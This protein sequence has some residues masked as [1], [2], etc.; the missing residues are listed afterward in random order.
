[1]RFW[2]QHIG[3][4]LIT[5]ICKR[6]EKKVLSWRKTYHFPTFSIH[7]FGRKLLSRLFLLAFFSV[8]LHFYKLYCNK[9]TQNANTKYK[10]SNTAFCQFQGSS[11]YWNIKRFS[12]RKYAQEVN[13]L[14]L[15]A[16]KFHIHRIVQNCENCPNFEN[17][18]F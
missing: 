7:S 4:C 10:V 16:F 12:F 8:T 9:K 11:W 6:Y 2:T 15:N 14:Y 1:M 18:I 5:E 17:R 3:K 13:I